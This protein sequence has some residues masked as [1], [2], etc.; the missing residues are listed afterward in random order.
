MADGFVKLDRSLLDKPIFQN[1]KL[2]KIW[3]WCLL[4]ASHHHREYSIGLRKIVL[5]QGQFITGR[6]AAAEELNMNPSTVWK[7]L[8]KLQDNKSLD[9]KSNNKFSIVTIVN[10]EF[11]Q[12]EKFKNDSKSDSKITTKEQQNNTDKKVKKKDIQQNKYSV[13]ASEVTTL[14][15]SRLLEKGVTLPRDWHLKSLPVAERLLARISLD[16]IKACIEWAVKDRYWG[17]QVDSMSTIERALPKYQLSRQ[18]Q[19]NHFSDRRNVCNLPDAR[20]LAKMR[21]QQRG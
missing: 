10:W 19:D 14:L 18:Q 20:E 17:A 2:L 5:K 16:E 7:Y 11:Y 12:V 6:F 3:V 4:K 13:G 1:E 21:E 8:K 9:I 15:K